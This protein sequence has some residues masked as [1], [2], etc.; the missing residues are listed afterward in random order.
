MV[1]RLAVSLLGPADHEALAPQN[2][3]G[4]V[5]AKVTDRIDSLLQ[6]G[7]WTR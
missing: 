6:D 4:T 2:S 3:G 7:S 5:A 1:E